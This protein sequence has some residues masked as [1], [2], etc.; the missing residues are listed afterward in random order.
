MMKKEP[1]G[2]GYEYEYKR[3]AGRHNGGKEKE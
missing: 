1:S 2:G 3:T